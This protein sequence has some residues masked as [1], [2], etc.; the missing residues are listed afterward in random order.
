MQLTHCGQVTQYGIDLG[1]YCCY[2]NQ[3]WLSINGGHVQGHSLQV[4][5]LEELQILITKIY[6]KLHISNHSRISQGPMSEKNNG[7][8]LLW[9]KPP[10]HRTATLV[11]PLS[12]QKIDQDT[13]QSPKPRKFGFCVTAAARPLCVPSTTKTA[14]VVQQVVQRR[15]SGGRIIAMVAQWLPRSPDGGTVVA[16]VIAEWTLLV[17]QRRHNGGTRE[18]EASLKL[19]HSVYNSTHF[20]MGWPMAYP[21]ESI[22]R[23]RRCVC[24]PLPPLC[25][26]WATDLLGDLCSTVLNMFKTW[27]RPWHPWRGL[28]VLCATPEWP[29]QP[30]GLLCAFNSDLAGF[31]V[32]QG[33]HKGPCVKGV[34]PGSSHTA[35]L[36]TVWIS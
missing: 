19:I 5:T 20:F 31:V 34:L 25:D 4:K 33:R 21:C 14:V 35:A 18:A 30:F 10:L 3:W 22:L 27:R 23:P 15:Q 12:I 32:A 16:T 11:P 2:L 7:S 13:Q 6:L 29:R 9:L 24:L 26:L 28:N 8:H 1:E 36:F 17:G